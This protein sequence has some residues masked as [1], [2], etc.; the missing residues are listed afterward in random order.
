MHLLWGLGHAGAGV[1]GV[2]GLGQ[3]SWLFSRTPSPVRHGVV[4]ALSAQ[5]NSTLP[6]SRCLEGTLP[7]SMGFASFRGRSF[8]VTSGC[9]HISVVTLMVA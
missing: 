7:L 1:Q 8:A 2:G 5:S 3:T 4:G 6:K 9:F